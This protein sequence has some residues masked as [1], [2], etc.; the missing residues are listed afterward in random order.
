MI[1]LYKDGFRAPKDVFSQA[2]WA[3]L[4][5]TACVVLGAF[6]LIPALADMSAGVVIFFGAAIQL[7][8]TLVL[9]GLRQREKT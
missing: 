7:F 3:A 6:A 1:R 9:A 2:G 8:F 4:V 5:L